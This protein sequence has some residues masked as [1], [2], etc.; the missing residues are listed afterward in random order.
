ML[1]AD[2]FHFLRIAE[3]RPTPPHTWP[4]LPELPVGQSCQRGG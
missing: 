1:P 2:H 3:E 4:E